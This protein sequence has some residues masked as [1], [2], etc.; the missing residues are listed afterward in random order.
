MSAAQKVAA[1]TI[2]CQRLRDWL[3]A[4]PVQSLGVYH[5]IRQEPDLLA[6]Y[7]VLSEQGV[8]LSLPIIHGQDQALG[9]VRWIPGETLV[10]DA[11]GTSVPV[12]GEAV[13]PQALLIPCLGFNTARIRLGYGGGFYDRTLAQQPR[14]LA[15]GVAYA[16][17]LQQFAG[18]VHDIALDVIITSP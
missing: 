1:E 9:F 12:N 10:K 11:L 14:P 3:Q 17:G 16:H 18:E 5:P 8:H 7:N 15:I 4:H 13:Q 2:L 6:L